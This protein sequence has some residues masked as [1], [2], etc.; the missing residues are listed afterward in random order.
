MHDMTMLHALYSLACIRELVAS[1]A[2][3]HQHDCCLH[4]KKAIAAAR[5]PPQICLLLQFSVVA[6]VCVIQFSGIM[7][8]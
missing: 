3:V 6:L 4:S 7:H 2:P 5:D 1:R 8:L